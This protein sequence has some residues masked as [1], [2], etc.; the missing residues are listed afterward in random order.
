MA[1]KNDKHPHINLTNYSFKR[2]VRFVFDHP[3]APQHQLKWWESKKPYKEWP[4]KKEWYFLDRWDNYCNPRKLVLNVTWLFNNL[5]SL[6]K[7]SDDQINQ[8]LYCLAFGTHPSLI[9][10]LSD[11]SLSLKLRI[12]CIKSMVNLYRE[13]FSKRNIPD[14]SSMWWDWFEGVPR[15]WEKKPLSSD[16]KKLMKTMLDAL[17]EVLK[18]ESTLCQNGALHGLGHLNHPKGKKVIKKYLND[19][20]QIDLLTRKYAIKCMSGKIL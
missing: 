1:I 10:L 15:N 20:L 19:N 2:W 6:D 4:N 17:E 7:F 3:A 14:A 16:G 5:K 13:V 8:G 11:Q 9:N 12:T 18:M